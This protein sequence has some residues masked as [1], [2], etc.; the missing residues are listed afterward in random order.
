MPL[1]AAAPR[2]AESGA[3]W[4][5]LG[6]H[7]SRAQ[8]R[9]GG[10][11]RASVKADLELKLNQFTNVPCTV[12]HQFFNVPC[13]INSD[14]SF[15]R[16]NRKL[17]INH[18]NHFLLYKWSLNMSEWKTFVLAVDWRNSSMMMNFCDN[19]KSHCMPQLTPCSWRMQWK[20]N[21]KADVKLSEVHC[22]AK[23]CF[24]TQTSQGMVII[25]TFYLRYLIPSIFVLLE[26]NIS[27]LHQLLCLSGHIILWNS[28][29]VCSTKKTLLFSF[30]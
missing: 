6:Y 10:M 7:S 15:Y 22:T 21:T 11:V 26:R 27:S 5:A 9:V 13:W 3:H 12:Y 19:H 14:P 23:F 1:D 2:G 28:N 16:N 29:K 20:G 4:E 25:C 24:L 8:D 17:Q 30:F 18:S